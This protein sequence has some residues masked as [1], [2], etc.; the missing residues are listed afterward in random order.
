MKNLWGDCGTTSKITSGI[1]ARFTHSVI[2]ENDELVHNQGNNVKILGCF[3]MLSSWLKLRILDK[4]SAMFEPSLF[5]CIS[6]PVR[7]WG[8]G[9]PIISGFNT[10]NCQSKRFQNN[11][12]WEYAARAGSNTKYWWGR[13]IGFNKANCNNTYCRDH[14]DDA[15]ERIDWYACRWLQKT[16][17]KARKSGCKINEFMV[18]DTR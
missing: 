6:P 4:Y 11:S 3:D 1:R 16:Y 9:A 2:H 10:I 15:I 17:H 5:N 8:R 7:F 18:R 13:Q 12:L 14:F